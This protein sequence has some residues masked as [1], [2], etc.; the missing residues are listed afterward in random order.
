MHLGWYKMVDAQ[1]SSGCSL[2]VQCGGTSRQ[3][4][5]TWC[6]LAFNITFKF[7]VYDRCPS[8]INITGSSADGFVNA[9][10]WSNHWSK[11]DSIIQTVELHAYMDPGGAPFISSIFILMRRNINIG[12]MKVPE[13]EQQITAVVVS[14]RSAD[15]I[16]ATCLRPVL[17][18]TLVFCVGPVHKLVSSTLYILWGGM[19]CFSCVSLKT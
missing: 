19:F 12:G 18:N 17:A 3:M 6:S 13:A 15:V 9:M 10:K 11:T 5:V 7:F 1:T 16:L 4:I 14:P 8:N 2:W